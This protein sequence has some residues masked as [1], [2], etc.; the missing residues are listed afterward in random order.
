MKVGGLLLC[1]GG[2]I[3]L[4]GMDATAKGLGGAQ[5]GAFEI[6][7]VRYSGSTVWLSAYIALTRGAW[8]DLR[9]WRRHLL[10]GL[11]SVDIPDD[12]RLPSPAKMEVLTKYAGLARTLVL[13]ALEREDLSEQV[14]MATEARAIVR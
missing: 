6:A 7:L 9:N 5:L 13:L 12:G 10:R 2:M 14:R 3:L 4:C 11:L 1:F 8:P